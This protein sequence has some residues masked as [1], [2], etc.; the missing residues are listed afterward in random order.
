MKIALPAESVVFMPTV[1]SKNAHGN[2]MYSL[3]AIFSDTS[4]CNNTRV[5]LP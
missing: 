1:C 5:T 3:T 4:F 2:F